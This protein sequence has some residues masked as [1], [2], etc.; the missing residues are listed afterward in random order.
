M[1]RSATCY[2]NSSEIKR[3]I[4]FDYF[5]GWRAWKDIVDQLLINLQAILQLH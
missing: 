2:L 4:Y 5:I 1:I 3:E